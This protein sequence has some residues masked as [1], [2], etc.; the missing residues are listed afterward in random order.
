M[1]RFFPCANFFSSFSF[2]IFHFSIFVLLLSSPFLPILYFSVFL[3]FFSCII[4]FLC[5]SFFCLSL[6]FSL[7]LF[8]NLSVYPSICFSLFHFF[9]LFSFFPSLY[10]FFS[11]R[12]SFSFV[13]LFLCSFSF[14]CFI[15]FSL[16]SRG[17]LTPSWGT[18]LA[19]PCNSNYP[20]H[21]K[22]VIHQLL[23]EGFM[24]CGLFHC[25]RFKYR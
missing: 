17:K 22:S 25:R 4:M 6:C 23:T 10:P 7:F 8:I 9:L 16:R 5:F 21:S 3:I 11:F 12:S 1:S 2:F 19:P 14:F 20:L 13:L 15:L 18:P 24:R